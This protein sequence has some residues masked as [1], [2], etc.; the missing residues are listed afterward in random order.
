MAHSNSSLNQFLQCEK[1]YDL[2]YN[3]HLTPPCP[4]SIHLTFGTMAHEVLYK[5]G[6][7][8]DTQ[9]LNPPPE[10]ATI[11]PSEIAYPNEAA[12]FKITSWRN[13]FLPVVKK[14]AAIEEQL[15]S[16]NFVDDS[17]IQVER[18]IKLSLSP[19]ELREYGLLNNELPVPTMP[20]VGV[21]DLL[22]YTSTSA[23]IVDYKFSTKR[24][25]QDDFDMNSQLYLYALFVHLKYDIPL[26]N[27][28]IAYIDIPKQMFEMPIVLTKP[29]NGVVRLSRSKSQN[30]SQDMYIAAV[31]SIAETP[32][33]AEQ[34]LAEG[35]YYYDIVNELALNQPAY[36][37]K[38]YLDVEI[39]T[40]ITKD[41]VETAQ[42]ITL[43]D[44]NK[45]PYLRKHDSYSC[46]NCD[47]KSLCKPYLTEVFGGE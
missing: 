9:G 6:E 38:Q 36:L 23:I 24:K 13:Y 41:I 35:G 19:D 11:I 42:M 47:W 30:C 12:Y 16:E 4:P 26:H 25:D 8:R 7:L 27:I 17:D 2:N 33:Q 21:I 5:A 29:V 32:E 14:V 18:E 44:Q 20:L 3:K 37:S 46:K 15:R 28:Q 34:D 40:N 10:Y 39:F 22:L 31:K 45:L 1:M 43:K